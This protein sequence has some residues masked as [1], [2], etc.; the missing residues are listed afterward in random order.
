M[1][2]YDDYLPLWKEHLYT[3][4]ALE[5]PPIPPS[6]QLLHTPLIAEN[7]KVH[8]QS[9]P[10]QDLVNYFLDGLTAGFRICF[11]TPANLHATK[12]NMS[13]A[14]DHTTVVEDYFQA[15]L[16]H[17]RIFDPFARS[18]CQSIHVSR[19]RVIS[20][21]YQ[22]NKWHLIVDLSHPV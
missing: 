7:W 20:R 9:H 19:F 11:A 15:E 22:T 8:F 4:Q 13:P 2:S 14:T 16:D 10:N 12:R 1:Q 21:H 3:T 5:S 17:N 18:Q 6:A